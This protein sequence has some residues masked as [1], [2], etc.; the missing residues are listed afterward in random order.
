M[1]VNVSLVELYHDIIFYSFQ[2]LCIQ[3]PVLKLPTGGVA[4]CRARKTPENEV[5]ND[6][7]TDAWDHDMTDD[8]TPFWEAS[9]NE[10]DGRFK[11]EVEQPPGVFSSLYGEKILLQ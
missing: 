5:D 8:F 6:R 9:N 10:T 7:T 1:I 4:A 3:V 11:R 2:D